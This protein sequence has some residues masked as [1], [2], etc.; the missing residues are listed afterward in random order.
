[1]W[2]HRSVSDK[3]FKLTQRILPSETYVKL[4]DEVEAVVADA[5]KHKFDDAT[6]M[7]Y[8]PRKGPWEE[9]PASD[10]S[11]AD[12]R[13]RYIG[14]A[15]AKLLNT[16]I[17]LG[18]SWIDS[19]RFKF[20]RRIENISDY[21]KQKTV[22]NANMWTPKQ[23]FTTQTFFFC[24]TGDEE[25]MGGAILEGDTLN[26]N[27]LLL[28]A[29]DGKDFAEWEVILWGLGHRGVV[30]DSDPLDRVY[31]PSLMHRNVSFNNRVGWI[32]YSPAGFGK[33]ASGYLMTRPN[34]L[35]LACR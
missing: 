22:I 28:G 13:T 14:P 17:V 20:E 11:R 8:I 5:E 31:Y 24:S 19:D 29:K 30:P 35:D 16:N 1:M 32:R 18:S 15:S 26:E 27:H 33:D 6:F 21:L 12:A 25:R 10:H 2:E 9:I 4:M 23:L 7:T 34:Y 3:T